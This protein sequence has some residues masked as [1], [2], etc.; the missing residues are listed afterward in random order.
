MIS[1][2]I[3]SR[4]VFAAVW[5]ASAACY[6]AGQQFTG[7]GS[8]AAHPLYATLAVDYEKQGGAKLN[9]DPVGSSAGLQRIKGATADFGASDVALTSEQ[10]KRDNLICFPSA[11]SGVV[12]VLN[13]PGIQPGAL[14]LSG[15]LLASIFARKIRNWNDPAIA[16]LNPRLP[17]PD[18]PI[19]L[20]VRLDGSG[21][22]FNFTDYLS[23]VSPE[24]QRT[25]GRDF[26][27]RWPAE[28]I[29]VKGSG[30]VV[31]ALRQTPGA[32]AYVDFQYVRQHKLAYAQ[33]RNLDGKFVAPGAA[34][35]ASALQHSGWEGNARYEEMLTNKPGANSWPITMGTFVLIPQIAANPDQ[36]KAVLK[37]FTWSFVHAD[38]V[39]ESAN[40]VRLPDKVL[41]RIYGEMTKVTDKNGV[42][43]NWSINKL[44]DLR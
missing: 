4:F 23:K 40:F 37:F 18:M 44:V 41:G 16:A 27:V 24:W 36:T 1:L 12:P 10:A 17:L 15:E 11:I 9:Y 6:G 19:V 14:R 34:G 29:A 31:K 30:D 5:F 26:K 25:F 35:F 3:I 42:S 22:T 43:L 33:L 21:S 38:G 32:M 2:K 20:F 13:V 7:A 8:S 39:V 28:A